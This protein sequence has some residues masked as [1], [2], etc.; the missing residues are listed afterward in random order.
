VFV[1]LTYGGWN[2]A[3]YISAEMRGRRRSLA[4]ALLWGIAIITGI[5]LLVN[6]AYLRGLGLA[7]MA[8]SEAV[9]ADLIRRW[10]GERDAVLVSV[11]V[12][13]SS[14]TSANATV[15]TGAR[16]NYALGRDFRIFRSLGRW[17]PWAGP[18]GNAL[19]LQGA[20]ALALVVLGSFTRS[21]FVTMVE[22]TASVFWA[23]FLLTGLAVIVLRRRN[24]ESARPFTVPLYPWTPLAFCASSAYMLWSSLAHIRVSAPWSAWEFSP[25]AC[26]CSPGRGSKTKERTSRWIRQRKPDFEWGGWSRS[27]WRSRSPRS[28]GDPLIPKER[29]ARLRKNMSRS[30]RRFLTSRRGKTSS[31]RCSA[32]RW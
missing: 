7:G 14:A 15:L 3:A 27:R 29:G 22:Y 12:A 31:T 9:A 32:W 13:I 11:L 23:F 16:A 25:P 5:Y 18:P 8:G 30:G 17:R 20:I 1:L 28:H 24:P 4:R 10:L 6:V 21:G 2:E 26:P 19:L